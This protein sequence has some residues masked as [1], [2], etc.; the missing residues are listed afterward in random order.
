MTGRPA[1]PAHGI[2]LT[3]LVTFEYANGALGQLWYSWEIPSLL[4]GLRL[5]AIYG[6]AATVTFETNGLFVLEAGRRRR[7]TLPGID[8]VRGYRAMFTEF[9]DAIRGNREPAY[10]LDHARRDLACIESLCR[11]PVRSGERPTLKG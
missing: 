8:D 2:D 11:T 5:S 7:L 6:T 3:W 4:R 1:G 9:L 10:T